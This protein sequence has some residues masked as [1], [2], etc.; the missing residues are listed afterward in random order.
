MTSLLYDLRE[1][2]GECAQ[3]DAKKMVWITFL[4]TDCGDFGKYIS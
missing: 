1:I 2:T 4:A 3:N